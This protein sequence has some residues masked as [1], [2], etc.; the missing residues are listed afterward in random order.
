MKKIIHLTLFLAIVSAIAGGALAFANQITQPII[1]ANAE[2]AE[3]E[4]LIELF[5]GSSE[6]DFEQ[7]EYDGDSKTIQK[8]YQYKDEALVFSMSVSGY[9]EGTTFLVAIDEQGMVVNYKGMTNGDTSGLGTRVL[10]DEDFI[11]GLIGHDA[12]GEL[13]TISGATISSR[14]V[15]DGINEAA[16]VAA[17]MRE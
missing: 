8:I 1:T 6:S 5:P 14:A 10:D 13:D 15:V 4:S 16:Q 9:S 12:S 11:N 7:I 2:A 3:K 17:S